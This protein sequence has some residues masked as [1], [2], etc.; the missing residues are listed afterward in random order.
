[1]KYKI[2]IVSIFLI[3]ISSEILSAQPQKRLRE[4]SVKEEINQYFQ[5]YYSGMYE[6]DD[7]VDIDSLRGDK[8]YLYASIQNPYGMLT[9]S[10]VFVTKVNENYQGMVEGNRAGIYKEGNV[11]WLSEPK[12]P[13]DF[14]NIFA[15]D[16]INLDGTV[17]IIIQ[18]GLG[19]ISLKIF[20]WNGNSGHLLNSQ[21]IVGQEYA[22]GFV[23]VEGDGIQEIRNLSYYDGSEVWSWNGSEYGKWINTPLA[24]P[25]ELYPA[26]NFVP[27]ISCSINQQTDTLTYSYDVQN[28]VQSK[29]RINLFWV[30]ADVDGNKLKKVT[31]AH[32]VGSGYANHLEG[33]GAPTL[34]DGYLIWPGEAVGGFKFITTSLPTIVSYATQAYNVAPSTDSMSSSEALAIYELNRTENMVWGKTIGPRE[35]DDTLNTKGFLDSLLNYN[36]KSYELGWI[37]NQTTTS[38]YDS[39]YTRAKYLLVNNHIPYVEST[40]QSILQELDNDTLSN[41]TS[42]AY[43]FLKFNTEYLLD[44]LPDEIPPVLNSVSPAT[45]LSYFSLGELN[46]LTITL[47]GSHFNDSTIAYFNGN[48]FQ[49]NYASDSIITFSINSIV[50]RTATDFPIWLSNYD[51]ISDTMYL[52]VVDS[53]LKRLTLYLNAFK[54]MATVLIRHITVIII[55]T[56]S[57]LVLYHQ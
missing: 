50:M 11:I 7:I 43:A 54:T 6:V 42:E 39:L 30:V 3:L 13:T 8:K 21:D 38:K 2:L 37:E 45:A 33:W 9:N 27:Y 22:M 51:S 56:V 12:I 25:T 29:Q 16:D 23:D 48:T 46:A 34:N 36:Q 5:N 41:I 52:S 19:T 57:L 24:P 53:Y 32:W 14:N 10:F 40:L 49:P 47:S 17:E 1:M 15:V 28:D 26:N 4:S 55:T 31:P 20:S 18:S 44:N 35:L